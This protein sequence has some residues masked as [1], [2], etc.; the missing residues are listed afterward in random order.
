MQEIED[1][2]NQMKPSSVARIFGGVSYPD[3]HV[4]VA[5]DNSD[6]QYAFHLGN[7]GLSSFVGTN[8]DIDIADD[9]VMFFDF[10]PVPQPYAYWIEEI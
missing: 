1:F 3:L 5:N 2:I 4:W 8:T 6:K 7:W 10:K 9:K